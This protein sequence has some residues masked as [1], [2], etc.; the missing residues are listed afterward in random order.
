MKKLKPVGVEDR[1]GQ[2]HRGREGGAP[3]SLQG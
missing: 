2:E 3:E 1:S